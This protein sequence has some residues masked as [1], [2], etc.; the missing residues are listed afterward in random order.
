MIDNLAVLFACLG[1]IVV[2][3]RLRQHEISRQGSE[4][5]ASA[6]TEKL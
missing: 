2:V 4:R 6:Q 5:A 3:W 1:L